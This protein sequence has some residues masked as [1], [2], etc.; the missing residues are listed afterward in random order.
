M[1]QKAIIM[2]TFPPPMEDLHIITYAQNV[3]AHMAIRPL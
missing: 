2:I 1:I 3:K